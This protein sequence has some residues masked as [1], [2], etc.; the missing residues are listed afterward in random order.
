MPNNQLLTN[1][2][3]LFPFIGSVLWRNWNC[4]LIQAFRHHFIFFRHSSCIHVFSASILLH[5]LG[6]D[7]TDRLQSHQC[8]SYDGTDRRISLLL[9]LYINFIS[10]QGQHKI[11]YKI[12]LMAVNEDRN[13]NNLW[14]SKQCWLVLGSGV[15]N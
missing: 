10:P 13:I 2:Y 1:G 5:L 3:D 8:T 12:Q 7:W 9:F 11:Q 15:F 14:K 4:I 6:N